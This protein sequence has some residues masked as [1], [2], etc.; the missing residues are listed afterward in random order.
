MADNASS[1]CLYL[2]KEVKLRK[3]YSES[4]NIATLTYSFYEL[5]TQFNDESQRFT[6]LICSSCYSGLRAIRGNLELKTNDYFNDSNKEL[7]A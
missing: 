1:K 2:V 3:R 5:M 7:E 4:L 6:S